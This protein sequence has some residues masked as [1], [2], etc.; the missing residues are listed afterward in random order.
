[1]IKSLCQTAFDQDRDSLTDKK[2]LDD[3][4]ALA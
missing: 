1:M 3:G 4:F 2:T